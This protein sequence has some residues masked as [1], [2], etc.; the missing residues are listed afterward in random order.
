M[1]R[2]YP[3]KLKLLLVS[4]FVECAIAFACTCLFLYRFFGDLITRVFGPLFL[5]PIVIGAIFTCHSFQVILLI[6]KYYPTEDI[7]DRFINIFYITVVISTIIQ[8]LLVLGFIA[9]LVEEQNPP[10]AGDSSILVLFI[11]I[12]TII[13]L[14]VLNSIGGSQLIKTIRR[15]RRKKFVDSFD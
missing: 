14:Q 3:T 10:Y 11:A 9:N 4:A 8:L 12:G 13:L 2:T 6:R 15:N 7:S 1:T 5:I